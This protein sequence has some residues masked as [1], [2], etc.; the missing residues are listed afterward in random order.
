[1]GNVVKEKISSGWKTHTKNRVILCW[2][3]LPFP[4]NAVLKI[5]QSSVCL[6]KG[7]MALFLARFPNNEN[8]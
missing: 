8:G 7:R 4:W 2:F 3:V 6:P 5:A 1:M